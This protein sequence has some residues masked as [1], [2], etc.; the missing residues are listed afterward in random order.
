MKMLLI[1]FIFYTS[2]ASA[3]VQT[4]VNKVDDL[5]DQ[6]TGNKEEL[7]K[8]ADQDRGN[9]IK[10]LET[11]EVIGIIPG[12]EQ[13]ES[14]IS[15]LNSISETDLDNA[16]RS[17]RA[18]AEFKFYDENEFEP[19]YSKPGHMA[20]KQDADD[21][22]EAT[23]TLIG[24]LTLKLKDLNIDCKTVKGPVV[25]EPTHLIEIKREDQKNTEYDQF[26]C[27]EPRNKYNCSNTLNLK[28]ARRGPP[29]LKY[30]TVSYSEIP[31]EWL[32]TGEKNIYYHLVAHIHPT[33]RI[34]LQESL[35]FMSL[36]NSRAGRSDIVWTNHYTRVCFARVSE[37][38][39]HVVINGTLH[40][41]VETVN[42]GM[43]DG[44]LPIKIHYY[45]PDGGECIE[46]AED[47]TER[48]T[49]Q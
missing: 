35:N 45:I 4:N 32:N 28:C 39:Y 18:S 15:E 12:I 10:S 46:W 1:L 44:S 41:F 48:C 16:G 26:I 31:S 37:I 8:A 14:H 3:A 11:K 7:F 29:E 27:E 2:Y 20:H 13:S 47:W 25:R 42:Y 23:G 38:L 21:I 40:K 22:A 33:I 17:K 34:A 5:F 36:I 19:D 9:A 43:D 30:I 49:L 24:D 6:N